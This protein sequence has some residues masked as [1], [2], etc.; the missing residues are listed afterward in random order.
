MVSI[1]I[2]IKSNRLRELASRAPKLAAGVIRTT[3]AEIA[4]DAQQRA[5]VD[6]GALRD[7][8]KGR[9]INQQAGEVTAGGGE[10]DYA[11]YVEYGTVKMG[12]QPYMH[13]AADAARPRFEAAVAQA[14]AGLG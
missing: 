6:T 7:S 9:V 3:V 10:V 2:E 11:G 8:I 4:A 13:P 14:I 1:S 5:P 12:A